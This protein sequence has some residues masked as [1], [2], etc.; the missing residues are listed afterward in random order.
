[1]PGGGRGTH[2]ETT[3]NN[4]QRTP[5]CAEKSWRLEIPRPLMPRQFRPRPNRYTQY[6]RPKKKR[7]GGK[8]KWR[9]G[10]CRGTHR[11]EDRRDWS[12]KRRRQK[13]TRRYYRQDG[14]RTYIQGPVGMEASRYPRPL[15][16]GV[17]RRPGNPPYSDGAFTRHR[18]CRHWQRD[19]HR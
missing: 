1:M 2:A 7:K 12:E 8:G 18:G 11:E 13:R 9:G 16:S 6:R 3:K 15:G 19:P 4:R 10:Q 17:S 5:C 14:P